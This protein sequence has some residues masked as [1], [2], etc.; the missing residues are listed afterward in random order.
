MKKVVGYTRIST[1]DQS[2][3]SIPY[4]QE[5]IASFCEKNG[6]ELV[7]VFSDEGQSAKNFD[8]TYWKKLD[9]F[10]KDKKNNID[11]VVVLKY[12]RFSRN[13]VEALTVIES[14]EEIYKI[15]LLSV[16]EHIA[17]PYDSP[18]YFHIRTNMLLN[19]HHERLVIRE[20]TVN[21]I[22]KAKRLG[23][24]LSKAP[25]GYNNTKDAE[26]R[27]NLEVN[28][29]QAEIVYKIFDWFTSGYSLTMVKDEARALG[30]PRTGN[31]AIRRVLSNKLYVG[32]INCSLKS[33]QP[34][35]VKGRHVPIINE[36][37][38]T[39]AQLLLNRP[40]VS[41]QMNEVAFLKQ[42]IVCP[43]CRRPMTCSRSKGRTKY[44]WYYECS[45]HR[46][47]NR[48]EKAHSVFENILDELTFTPGQIEHFQTTMRK[49][50]SKHIK[51]N[52]GKL[53][54]MLTAKTEK[55]KM[56]QSVEEKYL[57]G[58]IDDETF[59]R[60]RT[61]LKEELQNLSTQIE[62]I[63]T[64]ENKYWTAIIKEFDVLSSLKDVFHSASLVQ[65]QSFI[66]IGF[67]KGLSWDGSVYR[68]TYLNPIFMS[69]MLVM[70]RKG[71][72][73][74]EQKKEDFLEVPFGAP[75]GN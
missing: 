51:E 5:Q 14:L 69:K 12:D 4:Q 43:K 61:K 38:F 57:K 18:F 45:T 59:A 11:F 36:D 42:V 60:W 21:G 13:L 24:Y 54:Q 68:T 62:M 15:R 2:H 72:L 17:I 65:K 31:M 16:M 55:L 53:P 56:I 20:R 67:G 25:F 71:I 33:E 29:E 73:I 70:R 66:E 40:K 48:V 27:P 49:N 37:M 41:V 39:R 34:E 26:G 1:E 46:K 58:T 3:F 7:K 28:F 64:Q 32:L 10:L 30:F 75:D 6:F 63:Q 19:A 52:F 23:F 47:G 44:Y 8:R 9:A 35:Y 74:Y 22:K 50:V